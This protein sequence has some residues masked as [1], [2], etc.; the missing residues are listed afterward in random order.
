MD[1]ILGCLRG[2]GVGSEMN[3]CHGGDE[4]PGPLEGTRGAEQEAE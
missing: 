1:F 4:S 2:L 3:S